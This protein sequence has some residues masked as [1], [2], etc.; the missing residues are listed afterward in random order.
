[1]GYERKIRQDDL[2]LGQLW[3]EQTWEKSP[4]NTT[5]PP[6]MSLIYFSALMVAGNEKHFEC[7]KILLEANAS[8]T[9]LN[10]FD[11]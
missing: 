2:Y 4:A 7:V 9:I 10:S 11:E 1:M 3:A 8:V 5:I 6:C